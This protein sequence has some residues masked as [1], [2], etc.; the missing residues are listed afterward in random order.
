MHV[1]CTFQGSCPGWVLFGGSVCIITVVQLGCGDL[2]GQPISMPCVSSGIELLQ[3]LVAC[4]IPRC[5]QRL[6]FGGQGCVP[7]D[8]RH[9]P[10]QDNLSDNSN[11]ISLAN[12]L[13]VTFG[14]R[15]IG[16]TACYEQAIR[17]SS[18]SLDV[19]GQPRIGM[20]SSIEQSTALSTA[21]LAVTQ[22]ADTA[23]RPDPILLG[24]SD[25]T[26]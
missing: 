1:S 17:P 16:G 21:S 7:T 8:H 25:V 26:I 11:A 15:Q 24:Q 5:L 18:G 23:A 4:P 3:P 12:Q 14:C 2:S 19:I 13:P 10:W 6:S 9:I 20:H 22:Q